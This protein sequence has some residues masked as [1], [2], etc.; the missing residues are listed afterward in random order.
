[1]AKVGFEY[2]AAAKLNDAVSTSKATAV[3]TEGREIGP[4]ANFNGTPTSSDVKDFGDDRTLETD[5][6]VTG[7][8]LSLELN[9]PTMENEAWILGHNYEDTGGGMLR[10]VNDIAPYLGIGCVGKSKR[11]GALVFRAKIY[12]KTQFRVPNDEN[13]TKQDQVTF[14]HTTMEGNIFQLKNGDWKDEK[15]FDTLEDAK[16]YINTTLNITEDEEEELGGGA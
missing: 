16:E 5:T 1:M 15:E 14:G 3:Y 10:N 9:E 7:G 13:A 11:N 8:T 6:S 12:L 4:A 2:V